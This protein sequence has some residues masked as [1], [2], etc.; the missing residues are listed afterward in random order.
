M[1]LTAVLAFSCPWMF[2]WFST[3]YTTYAL[4]LTMLGM[5]F[6]LTIDEFVGIFKNRPYLLLLGLGLQYTILP[7]LGLLYSKLAHL[8]AP[9]AT[10]LILVSCC[11]GGTA[12]NIVA[13]VARGDMALS[14]MMTTASTL[15][16]IVATPLL[17]A[18]L[19]GTLVPVDAAALCVSTVQVR[20]G[21]HAAP[22]VQ[23]PTQLP[24]PGLMV[25]DPQI[26]NRD[27]SRRL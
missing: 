27:P 8:S 13:Y 19:V 12:S 24:G 22:A 3:Q 7:S 1:I 25:V 23:P 15:A 2:T 17:T 14:I 18:K 21:C 20:T 4:A 5:G 26:W 11:P 10:G 9:L 6:T 16:A